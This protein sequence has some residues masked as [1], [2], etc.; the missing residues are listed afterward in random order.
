MLASFD[1]S[2][3]WSN[4]EQLRRISL[5]NKDGLTLRASGV[6]IR[7]HVGDESADVNIATSDSASAGRPKSSRLTTHS[8]RPPPTRTPTIMAKAALVLPSVAKKEEPK[9]EMYKQ[10]WSVFEQRLLE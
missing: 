2:S 5:R 9:S 8:L 6:H 7:C 4:G 3:D 10:A 1:L